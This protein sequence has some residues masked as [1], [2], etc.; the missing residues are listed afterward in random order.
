MAA[1]VIGDYEILGELGQ[2]AM[3]VVYKAI[4]QIA[5]WINQQVEGLSS[6]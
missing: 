3:G 1:N 4:D 2:R 6:F 5:L